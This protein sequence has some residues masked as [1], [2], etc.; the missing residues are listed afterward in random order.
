MHKRIF[1]ATILALLIIGLSLLDASAKSLR[2]GSVGLSGELLPLWVAQDKDLFKKNGLDTEVITFHQAGPAPIQSLLAGEIQFAVTGTSTGTNAKIGG[3]EIVA[4]AEFVNTLPYTLVAS[5][6]IRSADQ[7][8]GKRF[9]VSRLGAISDISLRK[10]LRSLGINPEKEAVIL[11]IGDQTLR[12]GAMKGGS[13]DA[14]IISPPLTVT[15]RKLGFNLITSFQRAG[16]KWAYD[17]VYITVAFGHKNRE[18]VLNFLKGFVEAMAYIH[19]NKEESLR[20]LGKWM[21]LTDREALDETYDHLMEILPR[22]PYSLD[23]GMQALIDAIAATNPKAKGFTP[24][25]FNDMS[26]IQELDRSG[27]I[28]RVYQ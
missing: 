22:K 18:T 4:I 7:L 12:F 20:V 14:T 16:I 15:A 17:S 25:D 1:R 2:V 19:K 26:Y 5:Q 24:Q 11:G 21:R 28:D 23:E 9:A 27:F 13:V 10:A 6:K 8:K 3:A